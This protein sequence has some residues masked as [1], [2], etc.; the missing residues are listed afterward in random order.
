MFRSIKIKIK[1]L[2][3]IIPPI[4]TNRTTTSN[5]KPL[6]TKKTSTYG[7]GN[8]GHGFEQAQNCGGIFFN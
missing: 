7:F 5:L 2:W 4:S 3:L 1:Q 8:Q 6:N